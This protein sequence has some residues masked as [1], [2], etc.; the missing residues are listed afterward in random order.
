MQAGL[1]FF[2]TRSK[3][4]STHVKVEVDGEFHIAKCEYPRDEPNFILHYDEWT[5]NIQNDLERAKF[6]EV[7]RPQ[8]RGFNKAVRKIDV[9][10]D[11]E[12]KQAQAEIL[13]DTNIV[14]WTKDL[15]A[16]KWNIARKT[17]NILLDSLIK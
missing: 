10:V 3:L 12:L 13:K 4:K 14:S 1:L 16:L 15:N 6:F 9:I 17:T 5:G 7:L 2:E 8:R 11:R